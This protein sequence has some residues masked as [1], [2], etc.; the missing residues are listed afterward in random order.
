MP[1]IPKSELNRHREGLLFG[2]A[3]EAGELFPGDVAGRPLDELCDIAEYYDYLEIQP[4]GNNEFM[5]RSQQV[6]SRAELRGIQP[7]P[8][9]ELGERLGKPVVA[10][11][12]VHFLRPG[13]RDFPPHPDGR[14]GLQGCGQAGAAVSSHHRGNA[15]GIRLSRTRKRAHAVV[16]DNHPQDQRFRSTTCSL[17]LPDSTSR[18]SIAGSD[19]SVAGGRH[20]EPPS[21]STAIRCPSWWKSG[22]TRSWGRSSKTAFRS[23][24]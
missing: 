10:T 1:L 4:I 11:G 20:L 2:S 16:V 3:C 18:P 9:F 13:G 8:S 15:R 21:A 24:T 6:S 5:L 22:W 23:C 12:D 7:A 19:E 14:A 17:C